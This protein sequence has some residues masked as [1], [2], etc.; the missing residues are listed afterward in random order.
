MLHTGAVPRGASS[1]WDALEKTW[2]LDS[3]RRRHPTT[4]LK[5]RRGTRVSR[6]SAGQESRD[7]RLQAGR[8]CGR[9]AGLSKSRVPSGSSSD[10]AVRDSRSPRRSA[11]NGF[12]LGSEESC[13]LPGRPLWC[14]GR[15]GPG[16]RSSRGAGLP[17]PPAWLLAHTPSGVPR[18][19]RPPGKTRRLWIVRASC[20][21]HFRSCTLPLVKY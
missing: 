10:G 2:S 18:D 12:G 7:G 17:G 1:F 4:L 16:R 8:C 11:R 5:E 3:R 6:P 15:G 21:D 14:E 13:D 9:C 19:L 20:A